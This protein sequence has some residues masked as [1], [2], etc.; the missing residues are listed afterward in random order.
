[1]LDV[2]E[3]RFNK[4]GEIGGRSELRIDGEGVDVN[5]GVSSKSREAKGD[6]TPT[7]AAD[8]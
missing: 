8:A 6:L 5:G 1:M 2:T 4:F 3:W 7:S